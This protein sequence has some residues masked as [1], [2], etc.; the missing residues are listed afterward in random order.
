MQIP[1]FQGQSQ[2]AL[3][4]GLRMGGALQN[5][6]NLQQQRAFNEQM[7]P[8]QLERA[9]LQNQGLRAQQQ[10]AEQVNP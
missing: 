4:S 2:Q 7:Q 5:A 1:D 6:Q 9:Q 8:M 3:Q 10:Q